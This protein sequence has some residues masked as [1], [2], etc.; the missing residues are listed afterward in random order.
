MPGEAV[1]LGPFKGGLN[2]LNDPSAIR[3]DELADVVN[4]E[5]DV[6]G[7]LHVRPPI[8]NDPN[9]TPGTVSRLLYLGVY[10]T[11]IATFRIGS[12]LTN[13]LKYQGGVWSQLRATTTSTAACQYANKVYTISNNA[14]GPGF[15]YDGTT[16]ADVAT[17]PKGDCAVIWKERL[18]IG[19]GA[20]QGALLST[21]LNYSQPGDPTNW[22]VTGTSATAGSFDVGQGD[23]EPI[24]GL[25]V[26]NDNL[27]VFKTDSTWVISY[28]TDPRIPTVRKI[29]PNIGASGLFCVAQRQSEVYVNH[30]GEIFEFVNYNFTKIN[31][32]C[33]FTFDAA[34]P[35][36]TVAVEATFI[37]VMGD[38]LICRFWNRLYVYNFISK[39]WTRWESRDQHFGPLVRDPAD[40]SSNG[41]IRYYAG[42]Y[43]TPW[44]ENYQISDGW[45]TTDEE[46]MDCTITTKVYSVGEESKFKRLFWWGADLISQNNIQAT[47]IPI[48]TSLQTYWNDLRVYNWGQ[49]VSRNWENPLNVTTSVE[50]FV[51]LTPYSTGRRFVKFFQSLRFR[52]IQFTIYLAASGKTP[53]TRIFKLNTYISVKEKVV[54]RVS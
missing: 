35:G 50:S 5:V 23:G 25:L 41:V 47:A 14:S 29:S 49:L 54:A 27:L 24:T 43:I 34:A 17:M 20:S 33:P 6:D 4:F 9:G 53:I 3:D 16:V 10:V 40:I 8:I 7:S 26:Y 36:G 48:T 2:T 28:D 12:S 39:A 19:A 15:S 18:W 42:A 11:S 31:V 37:S 45:N 51:D 44:A 21:K 32:Q 52:E 38:R 22:T 13:M 46:T 30:E 1:V